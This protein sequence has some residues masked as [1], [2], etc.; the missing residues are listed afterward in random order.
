MTVICSTN[1]NRVIFF[2]R[3]PQTVWTMA[4]LRAGDAAQSSILPLWIQR[5]EVKKYGMPGIVALLSL[6]MAISPG[7]TMVWFVSPLV[8]FLLTIVGTAMG[9]GLGLG[10]ATHVHEHLER[11]SSRTTEKSPRTPTGGARKMAP[12]TK[13]TMGWDN[14]E[15]AY[16][17]FM[18]SAGYD[19]T[20]HLLRGQVVRPTA[21][22]FRKAYPFTDTTTPEN[23]RAV[24]LMQEQWPTLPAR[25]SFEV[26]K[27]MEHV[28]RDYVSSW[29]SYIDSGCEY[30][31]E[32]EKRKEQEE[33]RKYMEEN[34]IKEEPPMFDPR[35]RTMVFSTALH[36]PI[37][38][39]NEIYN[40]L[41]TIFGNL[42]TRVEGVN[43]LSL[44]LIK[45]VKVISQ[46]FRVYRRLRKEA[47]AKTQPAL[48]RQR[49]M[50]KTP[51][52]PPPVTKTPS[53]SSTGKED[54]ALQSTSHD[55]GL[56]TDSSTPEL[57]RPAKLAPVSEMAVTKQFLVKGKLHRAV[58]FGMDVPSLLFADSEGKDCGIGK[59]RKEGEEL[60]MTEEEVLEA[61][62]F[63]TRILKECELDYNRVLGY[64]LIR[65][66]LPRTEFSSLIV[67][68][69]L[70]EM[71]GGCVLN[72][73]MSCFCPEY[74]NGWILLACA[75]DEESKEQE[76]ETEKSEEPAEDGGNS[77]PVAEEGDEGLEVALGM[78]KNIGRQEDLE[79]EKQQDD[80]VASAPP[81]PRL[82]EV[83]RE[84]FTSDLEKE[85]SQGDF[86]SSTRDAVNI[87]EE[88][89]EPNAVDDTIDTIE[90]VDVLG[91][92]KNELAN[93]VPEDNEPDEPLPTGDFILPLLTMSLIELQRFMDFEECRDAQNNQDLL[94]I[95]WDD[96]G[97]QD[98]VT[99]LVLVIESALVHGRRREKLADQKVGQAQDQ[100]IESAVVNSSADVEVAISPRDRS[101]L[102]S[103]LLEM[104]S[105]IDSFE[106]RILEE[107]EA[108]DSSNQRE[109]CAQNKAAMKK[110]TASELKTLRSLIA[111]WLH[112]GQAHRIVSVLMN[113]ENSV[114][115][116]FY[117]K[118]SF[119]RTRDNVGGFVRQLRSLNG[120][121]ILV[122]TMSVLSAASMDINEDG[123]VV[124][125]KP[126]P[127][128]AQR[129]AVEATKPKE[130][131]LDSSKHG[132][133]RGGL[134]G[135][136]GGGGAQGNV[137]EDAEAKDSLKTV[138]LPSAYS[139]ASGTPRFLDFRRNE[140]FAAS[141]RSE[142]DR[143]MES[144]K[145]A[146]A[147]KAGLRIVV[148]MK[149]SSEN[150]V[151][152]HREMH[153]IARIFYAGTNMVAI[154]NGARRKEGGDQKSGEEQ[155][156]PLSLL[157]V[158]M[159][160]ARRRIE[161]PDDDSS[162]LLRAQVS[163]GAQP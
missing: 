138:S 59:E 127:K 83:V 5:E 103:V 161:V 22:F 84:E 41:G 150:E 149:G 74:V 42:C 104:T 21:K 44:L 46:T 92:S 80:V 67:R 13:K 64:R 77:V 135:L 34:N 128:Q 118:H 89:D 163:S 38:M 36:R 121:T 18:D 4:G 3:H 157:T 60:N 9:I 87:D 31:N 37:P 20:D 162:F 23:Y 144:W 81:P 82:D 32:R 19:V 98:A 137:S 106:D 27:F 142:R 10:L 6:A 111:A 123:D 122:D 57:P 7:T 51:P 107:E 50:R 153:Q 75:Q 147:D 76:E 58:T 134:R 54:S 65:A 71:M 28:V 68:T 105:D 140:N 119:I 40:A 11:M 113:A 85:N 152:V 131:K 26:G 16:S 129:V 130:E 132:S 94:D 61:R 88:E 53:S 102:V 33:R 141:L 159:T 136:I 24:R 116:P 69:M 47:L 86:F 99:Q 43:V 108:I 12:M 124:I 143:R 73:M 1:N 155:V 148:R 25:V 158:E 79:V 91:D 8:R 52:T 17:S 112:T 35:Q 78:S 15:T 49:S 72:P 56:S 66:L 114:L 39:L 109:M 115:K 100:G 70:A 160:S 125:P 55:E 2:H 126:E 101:T 154:R 93:E 96:P 97:C 139:Q 133:K 151:A 29:Y 45:W 117:F 30:Q 48:K 63:D 95:N 145:S 62:L 14:D 156:I 146:T 120:V 110:P 90:E